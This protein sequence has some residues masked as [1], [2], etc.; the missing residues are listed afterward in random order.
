MDDIE[1][2]KLTELKRRLALYKDMET[3][4]L[5]GGAQSYNVGNRQ[6][7]RYGLSLK[8]IQEKITDLEERINAIENGNSRWS[9]NLYPI[10]D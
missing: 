8:D 6:L 3:N 4:M 2:E 1:Y 10:D 7:S 5:T 9:G